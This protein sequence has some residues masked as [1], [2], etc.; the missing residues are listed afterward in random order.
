MSATHI[1]SRVAIRLARAVIVA[2]SILAA[3]TASSQTVGLQATISEVGSAQGAADLVNQRY[4]TGYP[5]LTA[6]VTAIGKHLPERPT[7]L[8]VIAGTYL[9]TSLAPVVL[10]RAV[11][12][13]V[14]LWPKVGRGELDDYRE[15][16]QQAINQLPSGDDLI[17]FAHSMGCMEAQLLLSTSQSIAG[18]RLKRALFFGC[19][20]LRGLPGDVQAAVSFY[21]IDGDPVPDLGAVASLLGGQ[22]EVPT[23]ARIL[24]TPPPDRLPGLLTQLPNAGTAG[25]AATERIAD[26]V[27]KMIRN[28]TSYADSP[29]LRSLPVIGGGDGT[30]E[31]DGESVREYPSDLWPV[32]DASPNGTCLASHP[33][34]AH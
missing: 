27:C 21:R 8:V 31:F 18:H 2:A 26:A 13:G 11:D 34:A 29:E 32:I 16:I 4:S 33:E 7:S 5:I 1:A 30:I 6:K 25:E 24:P 17:I 23:E 10:Q 19:P 9:P 22:W 28:H 20:E 12:T 3:K 14:L 15:R